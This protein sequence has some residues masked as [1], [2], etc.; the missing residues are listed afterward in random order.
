MLITDDFIIEDLGI[1]EEY[2]YDLEVEDNHNFFAN[3][4]LL[5]NSN[6]YSLQKIK[7]KIINDNDD[8]QT[9][10]DKMDNFIQKIVDPIIEDYNK[11]Y[12]EIFNLMQPDQVKA[13]REAISD[14]GVFVAKK[15]YFLRV[16]DMEGV[17]YE[18]PYMKR[19][20]IEIIRTSTPDFS[21]KYLNDSINIILDGDNSSLVKWL[22]EIKKKFTSV[23]IADIS[24][25]TG[26]SRIN[27]KEDDIIPI[28]SRAAIVYNKFITENNLTN[29]F[30]PIIAGDKIQ[31]VYLKE[32]N[33]FKSNIVAFNNPEFIENYRQYVDFD[34]NWDK[35]FLSPL[36]IM[37]E[38]LGYRLENVTTDSLDIW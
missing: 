26:V 33:I 2:V 16:Y 11:K 27:Y 36:K 20:G 25:R 29:Q 4:I 8:I 28:N 35:N 17:R 6:Y 32:P 31:I 34:L 18:D 24:K 22:N 5:H 14:K 10:V 38:S 3:D 12:C 1:K 19:M 7:N 13:E 37:T 23:P 9:K 15:R 30:N 21:K